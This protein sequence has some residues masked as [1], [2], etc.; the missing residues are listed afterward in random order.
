[1]GCA[2]L[3]GA[4]LRCRGSVFEGA[5]MA[6][7][8]QIGA[9]LRASVA[10]DGPSP[11]EVAAG[12]LGTAFE[13][14]A[15]AAR[16]HGIPGYV[17]RAVAGLSQLPPSEQV[18]LAEL[19]RETVR[20]H[21]RA[22]G[23]LRFLAG[24][25]DGGGI[26]WLVF[27]GPALAGPVHGAPELRFYRDLDLLIPPVRFG[28]AVRLLEEAGCRVPVHDWTYLREGLKGEIDVFMPS[29]THLDLHW[30]LLNEIPT[31]QPY[32]IDLEGLFDRRREIRVATDR[33]PT[34]SHSDT[35]VYVA[36][37]AMLSPTQRLVGMKDLQLLLEGTESGFAGLL[38]HARTWR[39]EFPFLAAVRQ[40]ERTI[41]PAA[42]VQ[43]PSTAG[44]ERTWEFVCRVAGRVSPLERQDGS[45]S[46]GR[47][48]AR[49]VRD[50]G[51]SSLAL[52]AKNSGIVMRNPSQLRSRRPGARGA[53]GVHSDRAPD[54]VVLDSQRE[55]YFSA[56]A[57][58]S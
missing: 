30:H 16:F 3:G 13:G 41:G 8:R 14:L 23:D 39:A 52:L 51:R 12:L 56:I 54:P 50:D 32:T 15:G 26:P 34:L 36:L 57:N 20:R 53:E 25:L 21:L 37:H 40:M 49:S 7:A 9:L 22:I 45:P 31:R 46:A 48:V 42:E 38:A 19:R 47:L 1:V 6:F 10:T 28:D 17:Y 29:G 18:S 11:V 27:K 4:I 24:V 33:F 58:Q 2:C 35:A 5:G 44:A 55:A 43:P